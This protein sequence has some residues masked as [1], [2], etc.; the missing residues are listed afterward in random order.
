MAVEVWSSRANAWPDGAIRERMR[1]RTL[2]SI[3]VIASEAKQSSFLE[4][5]W[6]KESWIASSQVLLAMTVMDSGHAFR[7]RGWI[8]PSFACNFLAPLIRGRGEAGRPMR[9]IAACAM[10]VVERTRVSQVTPESPGIPRAMVYGVYVLSPAIWSCLSPSPAPL[11]ANL[12]P[13]L[14]R[15]DHTTLPSASSAL[16]RSAIRVHR[17]PAP[18]W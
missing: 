7:S 18:R 5:R 1:R 8:H 2:Q 9:P 12:T 13:T 6:K 4:T 15:Q 3:N 16:V 14:R 11:S 10:V 17:I